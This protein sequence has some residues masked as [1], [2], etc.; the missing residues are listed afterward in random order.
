MRSRIRWNLVG[1]QPVLI[2][3]RA[4][5]RDVHAARMAA[6]PSNQEGQRHHAADPD[7]RF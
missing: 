1:E 5:M 4:A 6:T 2:F 7:Q 3:Q